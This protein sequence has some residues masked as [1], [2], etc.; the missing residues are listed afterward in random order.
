MTDAHVLVKANSE[1][2]PGYLEIT[3]AEADALDENGLPYEESDVREPL[4]V[5]AI[6]IVTAA[7]TTATSEIV[8]RIISRIS[9]RANK[10]QQE[11]TTEPLS[12]QVVVNN[13]TFALPQERVAAGEAVDALVR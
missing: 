12:I 8:K 5:L 10:D 9:D 2:Y 6:A 11:T 1:A 3:R 4:T 7:L 13:V